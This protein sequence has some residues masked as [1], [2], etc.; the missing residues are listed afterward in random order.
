[1]CSEYQDFSPLGDFTW[2]DHIF[3]E[4]LTKRKLERE[5][6]QLVMQEDIYVFLRRLSECFTGD[7]GVALPSKQAQ[8]ADTYEKW[9]KK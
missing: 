4:L 7:P 6:Q 9:R 1:M 8:L 2:A 5:R 3:L